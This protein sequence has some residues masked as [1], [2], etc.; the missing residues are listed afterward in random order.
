MECRVFEFGVYDTWLWRSYCIAL[1]C[2]TWNLEL[3][4]EPMV[5]TVLVQ[6]R[7]L[8]ITMQLHTLLGMKAWVHVHLYEFLY[9]FVGSMWWNILRYTMNNYI[10]HCATAYRA[11]DILCVCI[12]TRMLAW[13]SCIETNMRNDPFPSEVSNGLA[14][15]IVEILYAFPCIRKL[16]NYFEYYSTLLWDMICIYATLFSQVV[17]ATYVLWFLWWI[18]IVY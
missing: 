6:H 11:M 2:I 7:L 13:C 4:R 14:K 17:M 3:C 9:G 18:S 8:G 12:V 15:G 5:A 1:H 10:S 16:F